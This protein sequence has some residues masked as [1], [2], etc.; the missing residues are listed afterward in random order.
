MSYRRLASMSVPAM[1][2]AVVS[3]SVAG[4]APSQPSKMPAAVAID[5]AKI[6]PNNY[7]VPRTAW[8]DP[9]LQ[10]VWSYAT[11][12]PLQ[13]PDAQAGRETLTEAEIQALDEAQD[14]R[15]DAPPGSG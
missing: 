7:T 2:V 14:A 11:T 6:V 13:R 8:G 5:K 1:I 10:G 12:T 9:D 3:I 15:A 4:Q